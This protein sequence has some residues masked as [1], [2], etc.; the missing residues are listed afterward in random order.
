MSSFY[1]VLVY[2]QLMY[3]FLCVHACVI[4]SETQEIHKMVKCVEF[5]HWHSSMQG[6]MVLFSDACLRMCTYRYL[7]LEHVC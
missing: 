5:V 4:G 3:L 1:F 2:V 6:F 7:A